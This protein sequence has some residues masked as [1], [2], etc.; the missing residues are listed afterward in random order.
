[1][2]MAIAADVER[3]ELKS[4]LITAQESAALQILLEVCLP[5]DFEETV[6]LLMNLYASNELA[7]LLVLHY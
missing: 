7:V 2:P 6:N 4:A 5:Y 3:E 1:M